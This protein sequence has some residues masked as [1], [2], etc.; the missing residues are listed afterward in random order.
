MIIHKATEAKL[1]T[2]WLSGKRYISSKSQ[3][4]L[5][6]IIIAMHS[7]KIFRFELRFFLKFFKFL[8]K[9]FFVFRILFLLIK[10]LHTHY[11]QKNKKMQKNTEKFLLNFD[12]HFCHKMSIVSYTIM[13]GFNIF[14][15]VEWSFLSTFNSKNLRLWLLKW[16]VRFFLVFRKK[17][18][19]EQKFLQNFHLKYSFSHPKELCIH[20]WQQF[21]FLW[22]LDDY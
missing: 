18:E 17:R 20:R 12:I 22:F 21:L 11:I 9:C 16:K 7:I 13:K 14:Y 3:I 5:H 15:L 6:I 1:L 19:S 8:S 4:H 10:I 2:N